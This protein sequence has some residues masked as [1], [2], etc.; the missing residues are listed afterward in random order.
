MVPKC[1]KPIAA[2]A[3]PRVPFCFHLIGHGIMTGFVFFRFSLL[4]R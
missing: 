3:M 2:R 1:L 4:S